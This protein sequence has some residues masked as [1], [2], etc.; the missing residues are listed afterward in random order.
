MQTPISLTLLKIILFVAALLLIINGSLGLLSGKCVTPFLRSGQPA[1][2]ANGNIY[3]VAA[4]CLAIG[5][6]FLYFAWV[7]HKNDD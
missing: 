6:L 7:L 2:L 1:T 3:S 5:S 4:T